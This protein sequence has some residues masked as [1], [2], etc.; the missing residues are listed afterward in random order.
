LSDYKLGEKDVQKVV[1][2]FRHRGTTLGEH[3][4][5]TAEQIGEI[6]RLCL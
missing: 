5:I 6:L 1:E 2:R 3:Q 4:N